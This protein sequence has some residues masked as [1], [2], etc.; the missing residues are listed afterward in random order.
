MV[1]HQIKPQVYKS[2]IA[3]L[4][5]YKTTTQKTTRKQPLPALLFKSED[6]KV[7]THLLVLHVHV[8]QIYNHLKPMTL[9]SDY[10]SD[11]ALVGM[12]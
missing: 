7:I 11:I 10:K 5:R 8:Y 9:S 2:D 1:K 6:R 4:L 12:L 3:R